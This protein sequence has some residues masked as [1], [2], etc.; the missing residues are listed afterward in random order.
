MALIRALFK[1][2]AV[3]LSATATIAYVRDV[4]IEITKLKI[5]AGAT[6]K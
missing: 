2:S 6:L 3:L 1:P 5:L 4:G